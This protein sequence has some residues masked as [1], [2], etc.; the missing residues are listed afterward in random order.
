MT[1]S[2][3]FHQRSLRRAGSPWHELTTR[4]RLPFRVESALD[5]L[6]KDLSPDDFRKVYDAV[7]AI[8]G[9]R[10]VV[11]NMLAIGQHLNRL[12]YQVEPECFCRFMTEVLPALGIS[13]STGY[14]WLGHAQKLAVCFRNPVIREYL[15]ALTDGRGII[16]QG[17]KP[18]HAD[19]DRIVLT[20]AAER[21]IQK[22]GPA[23]TSVQNR[24]EC[25]LW[26]QAF[27]KEMGKARSQVRSPG[28]DLDKERNALVK[29]F[30]QFVSRYGLSF[31]EELCGRMDKILNE[32][33]EENGDHL[34]S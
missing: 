30:D 25:A 6:G 27:L 8:A 4:V 14:R 31:G 16:G 10:Q 18:E 15:T 29:R 26:V 12:R 5:A 24:T 11:I 20:P 21:A 7:K 28:P 32:R 9:S 34:A 1:A 23:P 3:K 19:H 33:A 2:P 22:T 17:Y 13:R